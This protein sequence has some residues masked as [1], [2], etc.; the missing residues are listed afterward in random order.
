MKDNGTLPMTVIR[1]L[2]AIGCPTL[3]LVALLAGRPLAAAELQLQV[4]D[5][6]G[7]PVAEAVVAMTPTVSSTSA[8]SA[9]RASDEPAYATMAQQNQAFAPAVLAISRGTRVKF[10][11]LDDT[12]HHVYSFSPAKVFELPLYKGDS[13]EPVEFDQSG[14]VAL[15]CN[16]H[17]NM[18]GYI[19]VADTPHVALSNA[20]GLATI[21]GLAEARYELNIWHARAEE[22]FAA[23]SLTID[24]QSQ[25]LTRR[26]PVT[27][28]RA[29]PVRGL[30]AWANQ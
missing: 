5:A 25:Q 13:H 10:P 29:A 3:V 12:Q 11:N 28:P 22:A 23:E 17:D 7:E 24:G 20:D 27:P 19:Y 16:I 1:T 2:Q 26:I 9:G 4:L 8:E 15:G 6:A 14:V 30:K 21:E 18:R